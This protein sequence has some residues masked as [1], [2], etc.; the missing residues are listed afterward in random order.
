[1]RDITTN[2]IGFLNKTYILIALDIFA[3]FL[4][5][6]RKLSATLE[7]FLIYRNM[8]VRLLVSQKKIKSS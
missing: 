7:R 5:P 8:Y 6:F 3:R 4:A 1:M 2:P